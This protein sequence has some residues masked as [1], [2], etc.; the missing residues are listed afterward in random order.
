MKKRVGIILDST[1]IS[2]QLMD[3]ISISKKSENYE[4]TVLVI[5][6][7][8]HKKRNIGLQIA[9]YIKRRGLQK[10]ISNAVFK[11]VCKMESTVLKRMTKFNNFNSSSQ[12]N[13]EDFVSINVNP[14]IS[15]SGLVY[16]YEYED[17]KRI[18]ELNLD[19]LIRGGS[20]ILRGDILDACPNGVISFHHADKDIN[21]GSPPGFWE[22]YD[23]SARTGF[24]IQRLKDELDGGDVLYKGF[25]STHWF[26]SLNRAHLCE[27]ANPF[28]HRV[29]EDIT[30][31]SPKL[32]VLKK[33]PYS[34]PLYTTPT[35]FQTLIYLLKTSYILGSKIAIK[36]QGKSLRWSV[37]YQFSKKWNEAMLWRSQRISNPKNR[38]LADPFVIKKNGSHF[39]FVED[40]DFNSNKGSIS[41]YKI[42]PSGYEAIGVVLEEDFHLSFPFIFEYENEIFM[43]PET[44]EKKEIRLYKCIDFPGKWEFHTT[45]MK[46]VS[47]AD[48]II[49]KNKDRWWLLTNIDQSCVADH[50]CQLHI[51]SSNNPMSDEWIAHENNPVIFDPLIARNGGLI[52]SDNEI[53]RVFQRQGFDMYGEGSG[54]A[55]ITRLSS[56]E[57]VEEIC[58]LIQP[59]FFEG[60]KGT[61][62]YNF[63]SDLIVLDYIEVCKK[64][65]GT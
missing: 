29:L 34:Y 56:T 27:V 21:R 22:V 24:V 25:V 48:T 64:N 43:C 1:S 9:S 36:L 10:F 6:N 41:A 52:L 38:F 31:E 7:V 12:L 13:K 53:Y 45:L 61:H 39:C 26:Y 33:S 60:I 20:G 4:I 55:R 49:F 19:L 35:V 17:I 23:R 3:L 50:G 59:K 2:K 5:N 40:L 57:Y 44:H 62:T 65:T 58:S 32:K 37:A 47:A 16:R 42:T 51:F 14:K 18:K 28:F 15:K 30:S 8:Q 63:D 54:I 11:F 46:N